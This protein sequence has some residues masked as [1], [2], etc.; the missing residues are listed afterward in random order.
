LKDR[1]ARAYPWLY[2]ALG[3][4]AEEHACV[5]VPA[6]PLADDPMTARLIAAVE[7][8]RDALIALTQALVRSPS[9]NPAG[10]HYA[11]C[12]QIVTDHLQAAGFETETIRA[13]GALADSDAYPRLNVIA[14]R[15]GTGPGPC[16]H[17]NSHY[18]VVPVGEGWTEDPFGGAIK[19][20][21]IYGRGTCDMKGGL[22][23]SMIAAEALAEIGGWPGVLEVS[24]V[25][26]EETGGF[27]G[28][29]WLA[30]NGYFSADRQDHVII[31]EPFNPDRICIGHRGVWWGELQVFGRIAHGSMP[32]LGD[33]A[34]RH[35]A[36]VIHAME[37]ELIPDLAARH[38]A[39]P[40]VPEGARVPTLN[41]ASL[42]GGQAEG[43]DGNLAPN[44]PDTARLIFD[45]RFIAEE[46]LADVQAEM[47]ALIGRVADARGFRWEL[48]DIF[49]VL[50]TLTDANGPVVRATSAAIHA[51]RGV[52]AQIVCSPGTYDQKHFDQIGGVHDCIAYGPGILDLAHQ[53]D[54]YVDIEDL[55]ASA[56]VMALAAWR[57]LNGRA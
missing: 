51:V 26:D 32:F 28:A 18:D 12:A 15:E 4:T 48:R 10:A 24:G 3:V 16:V 45:R 11:D 50:P 8:R 7:A 9:V 39:A 21:R 19:N 49:H 31:P 20:G 52:E 13:H 37:T 55:V 6:A 57:L 30:Q 35:M 40:V 2:A 14:R 53:P 36:A 1:S 34:V 17:F 43:A 56:K 54:E 22:A 29:A 42:H 23:A 5:T 46:Q 27:G 38:T 41:L 47:R 25:A 33:C 44:V